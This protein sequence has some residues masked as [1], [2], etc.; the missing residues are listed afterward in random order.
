MAPKFKKKKRKSGRPLIKLRSRGCADR[1]LDYKDLE[2]LET[3]LT[4]QG[5]ILSRRRTGYSAKCQRNLK[6]AIKRARHLAL[7]PFVG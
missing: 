5:Q 4:P 1:P 7:M 6:R 2:H 3:Y